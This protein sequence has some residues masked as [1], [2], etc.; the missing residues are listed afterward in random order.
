[1]SVLAAT[2]VALTLWAQPPGSPTLVDDGAPL[3]TFERLPGFSTVVSSHV[4]AVLGVEAL[5]DAN[6]FPLEPGMFVTLG[7][8]RIWAADRQIATLSSGRIADT[9]A[10][11][12]CGALCP[13]SLFDAFQA[14]WLALAIEA[15]QRTI[16][17][18]SNVVLAAHED[19]PVSTLLG[20]VYAIA[21]SRPL[22]P[23]TFALVLSSP[24]RGLRAQ[25]FHVVGPRGLRL[26]QGAA[27]LGLRVRFGG[28]RI[29]VA[30]EDAR[31]NRTLRGRD[32]AGLRTML[33]DVKKRHPGKQTVVLVPDEG[34]TVAELVEMMVAVRAEFPSIVLSAGQE[35]R[36]H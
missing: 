30:A 7:L 16:E 19:L 36:L 25:P 23:P 11:A 33:R 5:P 8:D 29:A 22:R 34:V 20:S 1:M 26:S 27:A 13:A 6:G 24:G 9:V 31:Y 28:G 17:I 18:P 15:T 32:V 4:A 21:T 10:A 2:L 35:L 14:E 12:E 3:Q